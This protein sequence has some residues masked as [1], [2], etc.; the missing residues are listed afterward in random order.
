MRNIQVSSD[1]MDHKIC[2][3]FSAQP[4]RLCQTTAAQW[5]RTATFSWHQVLFLWSLLD[6]KTMPIS[7][8]SDGI[9]KYCVENR[10][11]LIWRED[12][13]H[14]LQHR[15]WDTKWWDHTGTF[16]EDKWTSFLSCCVRDSLPFDFIRGIE[17]NESG[18]TTSYSLFLLKKK[19]W[20]EW[21]SKKR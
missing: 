18:E 21:M 5:W 6:H 1:K 20:K 16:L 3:E 14:F 13:P 11:Y 17:T 2:S 19:V 9:T 4:A 8:L 10:C 12:K 7:R 15:R